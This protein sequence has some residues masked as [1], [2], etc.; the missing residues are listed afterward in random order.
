[1]TATAGTG[2]AVRPGPGRSATATLRVHRLSDE[3]FAALGA[4]RPDAATLA[5][6]RRSQLSRHLL[7]LREIV[8]AVEV[9]GYAALAAA[10]REHP[11]R[12]RELLAR[13]LVGVWAVRCLSAL[14]AGESP[15]KTLL[16][17][18]STLPAE[19]RLPT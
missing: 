5:E 11:A 2:Q 4:G 1:M 8:A 16:G 3:A 9:P 13:P 18:L 14:R 17:Y 15:P 7:L 6:L 19:A 10:E 12:V